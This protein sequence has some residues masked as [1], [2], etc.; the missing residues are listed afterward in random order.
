MDAAQRPQWPVAA[1][2]QI[3][4]VPSPCLHRQAARGCPRRGT[5]PGFELNPKRDRSI[6]D[7][8][9]A[10]QLSA[11]R[12]RIVAEIRARTQRQSVRD[13]H[14]ASRAAQLGHQNGR[15]GLVALTGFDDFLRRD[16]KTATPGIVKQAAEQ[17][18]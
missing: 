9:R 5:P 7:D 4:V 1:N 3:E 12:R 10:E 16:R 6:E 11:P 8:G 2:V 17:R 14:Q 13:R 15:I 18:L